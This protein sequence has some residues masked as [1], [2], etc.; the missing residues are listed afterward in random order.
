MKTKLHIVT[1]FQFSIGVAAVLIA[2]LFF[3][4]SASAATTLYSTGFENPP[5]TTGP[6]AGQDGWS[7][8]G[9]SSAAQ[10]ENTV[11]Q[12]G[13]Q[14]VEV[15]PALAASQTGPFHTDPSAGPIVDL[16]AGL[17]IAS[18]S[19]QSEWQFAGLG[20]GLAPFLGGID[21]LSN[22][23]I[24]ATTKGGPAV[25]T[26]TYNQWNNVDLRFNIPSQTFSVF[27]NG[28]L[29]A[30]NLPDCGDDGP[31]TGGTFSNYTNGFFDAFPAALANDIGYMDNYSVTTSPAGVP[32][33]G[34]SWIL[35]G[36]AMC[37]LMLM[38]SRS[39]QVRES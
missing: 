17:Y 30:S 35:L 9:T 37:F 1:A 25:G 4:L 19:N 11:A 3:C 34:S 12:S 36:V 15:I 22:G 39:V 26:W 14:A 38:R 8:F 32:D 33:S 7:V 2:P 6:I 16:S 13:L 24:D 18:S 5:F 23:T 20:P 29:I 21:I 31:C 28:S 10:I 27:I